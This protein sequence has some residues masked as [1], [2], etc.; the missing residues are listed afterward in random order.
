MD[1]VGR[2]TNLI[3]G[4]YDAALD[5]GLWETVLRE[6]CEFVDGCASSLLSQD[7]AHKSGQFYFSWGDDPF[8]TNLY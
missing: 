7:S 2:I 3:G 6:T 4:V 5:P 8:Y 1:E